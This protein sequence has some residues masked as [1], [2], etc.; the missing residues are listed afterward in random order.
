MQSGHL[1]IQ[2]PL[3]AQSAISRQKLN[4]LRKRDKM[5]GDTLVL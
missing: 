5:A 1:L 2:I 3:K 4:E